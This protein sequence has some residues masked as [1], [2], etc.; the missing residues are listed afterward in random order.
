MCRT[1]VPEKERAFEKGQTDGCTTNLT[2]NTREDQP[3]TTVAG[4]R[5][6]RKKHATK[7]PRGEFHPENRDTANGPE[8]VFRDSPNRECPLDAGGQ[9]GRRLN[10]GRGCLE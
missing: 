3:K 4:I 1:T 10:K 7:Q 8:E 5:M 2:K 9:E 6:K